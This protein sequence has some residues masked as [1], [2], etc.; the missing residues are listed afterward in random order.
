MASGWLAF[1]HSFSPSC[2]L[3]P[4]EGGRYPPKDFAQLEDGLFS[5]LDPDLYCLAHVEFP[6][7]SLE[8]RWAF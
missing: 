7:R 2:V 8:W 6:D 1:Q 4:T 3:S 5:L